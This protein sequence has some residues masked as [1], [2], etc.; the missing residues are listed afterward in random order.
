MV[1]SEDIP[2]NLSRELLQEGALIRYRIMFLKYFSLK[3]KYYCYSRKLRTVLTNRILR[4]LHDKSQKD[5]GEYERFYRDYGIFLKEGII[6]S[7]EQLEKVFNCRLIRL[8]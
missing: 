7:H 4:F 1:D 6:T 8:K 5:K 3:I 2:L